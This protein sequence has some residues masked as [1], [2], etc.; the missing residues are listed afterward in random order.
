MWYSYTAPTNGLIKIGTSSTIPL[1]APAATLYRGS[2]GSLNQVGCG[3][4]TAQ[5]IP[6]TAGTSYYLMVAGGGSGTITIDVTT[7]NPPPNDLIENATPIS[8]LPFTASQDSVDATRSPSDPFSTCI[9]GAVP[10]VWY[11]FA[12]TSATVSSKRG[13]PEG[14]APT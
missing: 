4:G 12:A 13:P 14:S 1:G 7:P 6:V 2:P 10:T 5:I 8:A 3:G 11:S 9:G